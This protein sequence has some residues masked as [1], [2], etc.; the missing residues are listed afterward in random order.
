LADFVASSLID[1]LSGWRLFQTLVHLLGGSSETSSRSPQSRRK[2]TSPGRLSFGRC[3]PQSQLRATSSGFWSESESGRM[4]PQPECAGAGYPLRSRLTGQPQGC[5]RA[6]RETTASVVKS[7]AMPRYTIA[8]SLLSNA[9]APTA[10][11][12]IGV[13]CFSRPIVTLIGSHGQRLPDRGF[14]SMRKAHYRLP[15][16]NRSPWTP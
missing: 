13:P 8:K 5:R 9:S 7:K 1:F 6:A 4:R 16:N 14:L 11:G 2:F 15:E 10:L 3:T 12:A